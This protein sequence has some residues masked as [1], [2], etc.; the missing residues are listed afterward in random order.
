MGTWGVGIFDNDTA[1]D[2]RAEFRELVAGGIDPETAVERLVESHQVEPDTSDI[3]GDVDAIQFWTALAA[4][5]V[6]CGRL[7]ERVTQAVLEIDRTGADAQ[8]WQE[9]PAADQRRRAKALQKLVAQVTGPQRKPTRI[10]L[11][12]R[13]Q[14]DLNPGDCLAYRLLSGRWI[15]LRVFEISEGCPMFDVLEGEWDAPPTREQV[16][17]PRRR[18]PNEAVSRL[19]ELCMELNVPLPDLPADTPFPELRQA[20]ADVMPE[21]LRRAFRMQTRP[22]LWQVCRSGPKKGPG[23]RLRFIAS[24]IPLPTAATSVAVTH[25]DDFDECL[26]HDYDLE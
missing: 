1:E 2:V 26:R 18:Y 10:R 8:H 23:D 25:W 13:E 15:A 12:W 4:T 21:R 14:T 20:V 3:T 7:T 19:H 22:E 11:A 16:A 5:Q 17:C 24:D 9:L 6:Q